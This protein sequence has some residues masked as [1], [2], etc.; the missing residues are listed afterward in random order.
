MDSQLGLWPLGVGSL[1]GSSDEKPMKTTK[2]RPGGAGPLIRLCDL[3]LIQ[4]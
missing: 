2:D 3:L 1:Y 4:S